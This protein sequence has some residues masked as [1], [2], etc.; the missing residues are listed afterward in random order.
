MKAILTRDAY[1]DNPEY[2][3]LKADWCEGRGLP[4]T[5][6]K[7]IEAKAGEVIEH[8]EAYMLVRFGMAIPG[9]EECRV[10]AG[11]SEEQMVA[12]QAAQAKMN[13]LGAYDAPGLNET[14]AEE[15][16]ALKESDDGAES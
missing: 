10:K 5:V 3:Q 16:E 8:R 13:V 4:Y 11:V 6:P 2:D 7:V 12:L 14:L 9:D 1:R 15:K